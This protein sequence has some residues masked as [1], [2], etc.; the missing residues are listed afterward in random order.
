MEFY[1]DVSNDP[2]H[3]Q[4]EA[5]F[6]LFAAPFGAANF[7][8]P[9]ALREKVHA[10]AAQ[11]KVLAFLY[12]VPDTAGVELP[13]KIMVAHRVANFY[14]AMGS[15]TPWDNKQFAF[16]GDLQ[17]G[18]ISTVEL[19][20][21]MFHRVNQVRI[22]TLATA[23]ELA[24]NAP[25]ASLFGPFGAED[26]GT[27]LAAPRNVMFVPNIL[28]PIFLAAELQPIEAYRR[29]RQVS[30]QYGITE[31]IGPLLEWL[32]TAATHRGVGEP[33]RLVQPRLQPPIPSDALPILL[34]HR[35]QLLYRDL[36]LL[37][38][39][40]S[41]Q[42]QGQIAVQLSNI[43]QAQLQQLQLAHD[44]RMARTQPKPVSSLGMIVSTI[45]KLCQ[46]ASD[47]QLPPVYHAMAQATKDGPRRIILEQHLEQASL[48]YQ[49]FPAPV[50]TPAN[51]TKFVNAKWA[52]D[53]PME[54]KW[55]QSLQPFAIGYKYDTT[56]DREKAMIFDLISG[57]GAAPS[58]TDARLLT[59]PEQIVLPQSL[60]QAR[61]ALRHHL[62]YLVVGLGPQHAATVETHRFVA[63]LDQREPLI[64]A[65]YAY[66]PEARLLPTQIVLWYCIRFDMWARNQ[67]SAAHPLEFPNLQE[68]FTRMDLSEV[69][70]PP[71]PAKYLAPPTQAPVAPP[72]GAFL[73][74]RQPRPAPLPAPGQPGPNPQGPPQP[75]AAEPA[76]PVYNPQFDDRFQPLQKYKA[77]MREVYEYAAAHNIPLPTRLGGKME[78]CLAF[79]ARGMCNTRCGRNADHDPNRTPAEQQ[80]LFDWCARVF[81]L[82]NNMQA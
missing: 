33:S 59:E 39:N 63:A 18:Q 76:R 44:E 56:A 16:L 26:A 13:G 6:N 17:Y 71:I 60:S 43:N 81:P 21:D 49:V 80:E 42:Q 36:P 23:D 31:A 64:A 58:A 12:H 55:E 3:G 34:G 10:T 50:V 66:R 51:F 28:V 5:I 30:E 24:M 65:R 40:R 72:A 61:Q 45:T 9:L 47:M 15:E 7:E 41:N 75:A 79:H 29:V 70:E 68:L 32:R 46:V 67:R 57:G 62:L 78:R 74:P 20:Q 1:G 53:S 48:N 69:W 37:D 27:E 38:P 11:G 82:A 2:Y 35:M 77:R 52:M 54:D 14:P 4:Y 22:P 8:A 73:A 25:A 19:P